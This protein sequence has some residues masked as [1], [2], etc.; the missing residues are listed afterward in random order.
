MQ[1]GFGVFHPSFHSISSWGMEE[2]GSTHTAKQFGQ[3]LS[4]YWE[5]DGLFKQSKEMRAKGNSESVMLQATYSA[6]FS[7]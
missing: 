4:F 6:P 2:N 5:L 7:L 3:L 1:G